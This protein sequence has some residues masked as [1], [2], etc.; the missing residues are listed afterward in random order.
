[1]ANYIEFTNIRPTRFVTPTS[2]YVNSKV[3]YYTERKLISF[4]TYKKADIPIT[5]NDKYMVITKGLEY[6]PDLVSN[7][8]Y[9][10]PDLWWKILEANGMKDIYEFKAGENIRIPNAIF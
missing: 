10:F 7:R 5:N 8:A 2:R 9:G 1:M 3:I 6:R 4:N